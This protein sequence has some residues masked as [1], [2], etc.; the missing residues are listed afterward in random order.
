MGFEASGSWLHVMT[1]LQSRGIRELLTRDSLQEIWTAA[2]ST[3]KSM[4][5]LGFDRNKELFKYSVKVLPT[6]R[7]AMAVVTKGFRNFGYH[8]LNSEAKDALNERVKPKAPC[9]I[10]LLWV[11][12]GADYTEYAP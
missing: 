5:T 1:S 4:W 9:K 2:K 7:R 3:S 8:F 12:V 6:T 11:R 10:F